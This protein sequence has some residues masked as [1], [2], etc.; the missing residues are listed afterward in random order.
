[1]YRARCDDTAGLTRV[2]Y[3]GTLQGFYQD[4]AC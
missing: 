3:T 2:S 4:V 1:M